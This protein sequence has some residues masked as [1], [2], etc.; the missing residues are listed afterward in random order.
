MEP[1]RRLSTF[2]KIESL[3]TLLRSEKFWA[4]AVLA[5]RLEGPALFRVMTSYNLESTFER[6]W[7]SFWRLST[8]SPQRQRA[9]SLLMLTSKNL[10]K[11]IVMVAG[12]FSGNNPHPPGAAIT[13][14]AG[15]PRHL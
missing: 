9:S 4:A 12:W 11:M 1:L 15:C 6:D 7:N 5:G 13:E 8:D 3:A 14:G 10:Y 2:V